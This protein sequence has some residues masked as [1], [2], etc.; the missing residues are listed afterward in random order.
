MQC[1]HV[2]PLQSHVNP[3]IEVIILPRPNIK[4][5]KYLDPLMEALVMWCYV[6]LP[7][8]ILL[9]LWNYNKLMAFSHGWLLHNT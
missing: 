5:H 6:L 8:Y 2:T 1:D 7:I 3:N 4:T 9:C